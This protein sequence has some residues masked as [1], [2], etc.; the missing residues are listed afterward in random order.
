MKFITML[1]VALSMV[2]CAS[3]SGYKPT[4]NEKADKN[5]S[6]ASQDLAY[7]QELASATAG[8]TKDG[9]FDSLTGAAYGAAMGG[10]LGATV[11]A[12]AGPAAIAGLGVGGVTGLFYGMYD[13]DETYK[14]SYNSCMN[15]LGHAIL[16]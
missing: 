4:I 11:T 2:G 16:W 7:C 13:A 14:R 5:F 12:P 3:I 1:F 15:Q 8:Y 9:A 6:T 10:V